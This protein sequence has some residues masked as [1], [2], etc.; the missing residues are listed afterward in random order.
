VGNQTTARVRRR[1][2]AKQEKKEKRKKK[3]L[4]LGDRSGQSSL[5]VIDVANSSN[6]QMGLAPVKGGVVPQSSNSLIIKTTQNNTA[7]V[8]KTNRHRDM[9]K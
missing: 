5:A 8:K 7:E 6:V 2:L 9:K 4:T 1:G 3:L